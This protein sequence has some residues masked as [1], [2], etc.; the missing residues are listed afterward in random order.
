MALNSK[1]SGFVVTKPLRLQSG[2]GGVFN[3]TKIPSR[4]K[5]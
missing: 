5:S 3:L 2:N 1:R 4:K